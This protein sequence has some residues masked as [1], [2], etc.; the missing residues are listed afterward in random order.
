MSTLKQ[1]PENSFVEPQ[2]P[3]QSWT[4]AISTGVSAIA[5]WAFIVYELAARLQAPTIA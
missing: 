1:S 2:D 4:V 3:V 5:L